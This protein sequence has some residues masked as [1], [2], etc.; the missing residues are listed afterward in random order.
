M[1]HDPVNAAPGSIESLL[2]MISPFSLA[3][4]F[5]DSNCDVIIGI[6][7]KEYSHHKKIPENIRIILS[8]D[9]S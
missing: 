4:V 2:V 8:E 9:F 1:L 6:N 7:H 5:K 3:V